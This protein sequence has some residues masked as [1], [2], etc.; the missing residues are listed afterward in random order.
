MRIIQ[1]VS[2]IERSR[3]GYR[4]GRLSYRE[5]T[6]KENDEIALLRKSLEMQLTDGQF[7]FFSEVVESCGGKVFVKTPT[8]RA[9]IAHF[10]CEPDVSTL[11]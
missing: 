3:L 11:F 7:D 5:L 9:E 8:N 1:R 6:D 4:K 2:E 10:S